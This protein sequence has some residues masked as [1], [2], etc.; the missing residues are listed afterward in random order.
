MSPRFLTQHTLLYSPIS[1]LPK[2][3]LTCALLP[4]S[5][6]MW[7]KINFILMNEKCYDINETKACFVYDWK[8][9]RN[10]IRTHRLSMR[11]RNSLR[12]LLTRWVIGGS[13]TMSGCV[14]GSDEE[15]SELPSRGWYANTHTW[16]HPFRYKPNKALFDFSK[17]CYNSPPILMATFAAP[18]QVW[19]F[20]DFAYNYKTS[21]DIFHLFVQPIY[22]LKW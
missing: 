10:V 15:V 17:I 18:M 22:A 21:L 6:T 3:N 8:I 2:S 5:P 12:S 19:M 7:Y 9:E 14:C 16:G 13:L 4:H 20:D 1:L 11:M